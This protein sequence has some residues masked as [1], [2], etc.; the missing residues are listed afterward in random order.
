MIDEIPIITVS[1]NTPEL[2]INLIRSIRA[3]YRNTVYIIDGSDQPQ[4]AQ[5]R[6][7]ATSQQSVIFY[8]FGYNI[9]HGPG[10]AWAISALS[11]SGRVLFVDSDITIL[12]RGAIESLNELLDGEMYGVGA[13]G[14]V[15]REGFDVPSSQSPIRYLHPPF[16]LCNI[17]VMRQWPLP[18]KHGAPMIE[19]MMALHDSGKSTLIG[20]VPWVYTDISEGTEKLYINHLSRGTVTRTGGYHL[21]GWLA[22]LRSRPDGNRPDY[23]DSD[24]SY[25]PHLLQAIPHA[26]AT[27]IEVGCNAGAL[28]KAYK[29]ANPSAHYIGIE[30]DPASADRARTHCDQVLTCDV[31]AL[32][33]EFF[34]QHATV[35]C[36]VFG[37]VLEH[38]KDPWQILSQIRRVLPPSGS[39][40]ACIP[41]AQHWSVQLRLA[42]GSFRYEDGGLLDRTHLRWF[43]RTTISELFASTGY[44]VSEGISRTPQ[45]QIPAKVA[46]AIRSCAAAGGIDPEQAIADA[47]PIQYVVRAT[48]L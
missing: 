31:E 46:E 35:S 7:F 2:I 8:P 18:V 25:N 48:P 12:K 38:L 43:T 42:T 44:R 39:V 40:V 33:A 34:A 14:H 15:N 3:H 19:A 17:E 11:L 9:H 30:M 27:V 28:A 47:M 41:N 22:T 13:V 23:G 1:Y 6:D 26:C 21:D 36:W 10:M 16:M 4:A 29:A 32:P 20:H 37:D 5:I 24:S 45:A